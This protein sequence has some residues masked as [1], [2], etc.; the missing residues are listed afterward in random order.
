MKTKNSGFFLNGIFL[1]CF[2]AVSVLNLVANKLLPLF[3]G[4][5]EAELVGADDAAK[6]LLITVIGVIA[7]LSVASSLLQILLG[8]NSIKLAK[9]PE[10]TKIRSGLAKF[11]IALGSISLFAT[12]SSFPG[13]FS[14]AE[15][16]PTLLF[17]VT[18]IVIIIEY[19]F[20]TKRF[21]KS[22]EA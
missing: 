18:N 21:T 11:L 8:V 2:A 10:S 14:F 12:I 20:E 17:G 9:A 16:L 13:E 19:I 22:A 4:T 15:N 1:L 3:D 5:F 7:A 6:K